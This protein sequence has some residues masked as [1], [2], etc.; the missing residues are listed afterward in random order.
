MPQIITKSRCVDHLAL[1]RFI[2]GLFRSAGL[3]DGDAQLAATILVEANLRGIDSHGVA[4]V[5]HYLNRLRHGSINPLPKMQ[6]DQLSPAS[7]LLDGDHGLGH[8]VMYRAA[9]QAIEIAQHG[10]AGWVAVRNSSHCG[11]LA[12]YGEQIARAGMIAMVFT[13]VDSLV[14]PY[15]AKKPFCGTNPLCICAPMSID[16][17][18]SQDHPYVCLDMATSRVP[19]NTVANAAKEQVSIE[20]GWAV[21]K[22]GHDTNTAEQVAALHPMGDYKGSGLG[23]MID[24]LCSLLSGAPF[25]PD[26]SKMYGNPDERRYLGGLIGAIDI[27]RFVPLQSFCDRLTSMIEQWNDLPPTQPGSKVLYPGEPEWLIRKER[28]ATGVPIGLQVL[29]DLDEQAVF[30]GQSTLSSESSEATVMPE[31]HFSKEGLWRKRESAY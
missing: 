22:E 1:T 2:S 6:T 23:L 9:E 3:P 30:Y 21:D 19:W 15:G 31:P 11:S 13:H 27:A 24:V 20:L 4:R 12:Y 5:P 18:R 14:L 26:I 17:E 8:L 16:G 28:M 10:G 7:G 25:G 29:A